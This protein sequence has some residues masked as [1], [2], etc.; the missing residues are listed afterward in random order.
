[1]LQGGLAGG[2]SAEEL[3]LSVLLAAHLSRLGIDGGV[4]ALAFLGA[5]QR[6]RYRRAA[7]QADRADSV[8]DAERLID[9]EFWAAFIERTARSCALSGTLLPTPAFRERGEIF[10]AIA[11]N[12]TETAHAP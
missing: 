9:F 12:L 1:M 11:P 3:V 6:S 7:S 10:A 5:W 8:Y 2:P 4:A